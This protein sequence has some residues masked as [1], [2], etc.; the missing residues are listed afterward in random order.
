[1]TSFSI[2]SLPVLKM[3]RLKYLLYRHILTLEHKVFIFDEPDTH[4]HVKAQRELMEILEQIKQEA[5]VIITTHSPFILNSKLFDAI[6][7]TEDMKI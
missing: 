2:N 1:M 3:I 4:L 5:Q 7:P 6:K